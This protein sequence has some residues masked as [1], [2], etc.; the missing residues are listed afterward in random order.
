MSK[1]TDWIFDALWELS[2]RALDAKMPA[3]ADKIEEAM[4]TYLV[5]KSTVTV[6][7]I[8]H[9]QQ[10]FQSIE[11]KPTRIPAKL[12]RQVTAQKDFANLWAKP[13][14]APDFIST[15]SRVSA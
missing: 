6:L 10:N 2:D 12:V 5:E 4:D 11:T 13:E 1:N 9:T 14:T 8:E 15:R 7:A 3:L